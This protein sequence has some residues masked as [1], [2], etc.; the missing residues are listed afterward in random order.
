MS[1]GGLALTRANRTAG[2]AVVAAALAL[3]GVSL[4]AWAR[5]SATH[6]VEGARRDTAAL[7]DRVGGLLQTAVSTARLRAE[8][9]ARG[10]HMVTAPLGLLSA[11]SLAVRTALLPSGGG[12][13]W[14]G[15]L[16][17]LLAFVTALWTFVEHRR[18][19]DARDMAPLDDAVT[20]RRETYFMD[21]SAPTQPMEAMRTIKEK[22]RAGGGHPLALAWNESIPTP[23]TR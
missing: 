16:A 3:C 22:T 2:L 17:L 19:R 5:W 4:A 10:A 15:R 1:D 8:G 13:L 20:A 7:A 23:I 21:E 11:P 18:R 12:A 14:A 9:L 6:A